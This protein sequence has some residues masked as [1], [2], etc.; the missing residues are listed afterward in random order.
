MILGQEVIGLPQRFAYSVPAVVLAKVRS[1]AEKLCIL[2]KG[3]CVLPILAGN[4]TLLSVKV[5]H[6]YYKCYCCKLYIIRTDRDLVI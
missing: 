4:K 1:Y 3:C 6:G 5:R 2:T